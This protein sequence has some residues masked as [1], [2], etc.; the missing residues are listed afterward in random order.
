MRRN[1][2]GCPSGPPTSTSGPPSQATVRS[3]T[4][5]ISVGVRLAAVPSILVPGVLYGGEGA[6]DSDAAHAFNPSP[7][8][9]TTADRAAGRRTRGERLRRAAGAARHGHRAPEGDRRRVRHARRDAAALPDMAAGR[10]AGQFPLGGDAGAARH[11]R[12]PRCLGVSWP[13]IRRA[14]DRG[15]LPRPARLRRYVG[16]RLLARHAGAGRRCARRWR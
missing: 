5:M 13:R 3:S 12:Q 10:R 9:F 7:H 14:R 2:R 11:E 16:A 15:I 6:Y 1:T 4:W 8:A